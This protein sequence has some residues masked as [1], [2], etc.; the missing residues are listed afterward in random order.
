MLDKETVSCVFS[1]VLS[2]LPLNGN[3][4][5]PISTREISAEEAFLMVTLAGF[6]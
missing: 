6:N 2:S 4:K 5:V 3:V 1:Q